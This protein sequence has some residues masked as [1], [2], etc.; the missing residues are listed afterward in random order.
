MTLKL[1]SKQ[2][3]ELWMILSSYNDAG[4]EIYDGTETG[5]TLEYVISELLK[6]MK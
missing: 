5:K 6:G 2:A 1:T 4:A 3:K